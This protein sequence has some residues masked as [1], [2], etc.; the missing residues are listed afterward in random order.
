MQHIYMYSCSS[1]T[2]TVLCSTIFRLWF[3][4]VAKPAAMGLTALRLISTTVLTLSFHS[5]SAFFL[6]AVG[7]ALVCLR[8]TR[9]RRRPMPRALLSAA[10]TTTAC[11]TQTRTGIPK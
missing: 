1:Q 3:I 9:R 7:V 4:S 5:L 2:L 10:Q 6:R 8:A 11:A